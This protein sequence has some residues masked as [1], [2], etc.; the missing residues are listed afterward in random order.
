VAHLDRRGVLRIFGAVAVA[1]AIGS[2]SA[3]P[4][5]TETERPSGKAIRIGLV[6]PTQGPYAKIGD[7]IQK[8]FKLYLSSH[9]NL[10]GRHKVDLRTADEGTTPESASAAVKGLLEQKVIALA[11][12]ANPASLAAIAADVQEA[13]VPLVSSYAS[14]AT[15]TS[16][17]YVWRA[18]YVEGE[19][20][21]ALAPYAH[22][23][24]QSAYVLNE[25]TPAGREEASAFRSAFTDMGGR[26]V[27]QAE[28]RIPFATRLQVVK[29]S[30]AN[31]LFASYTGADAEA[32]LD[33]YRTS[34]LT[35]KLLGPASL[36]D[37]ADLSKLSALPSR[38]YTAMYYAADLNNEENRRFVSSY[39]NVHG[40]QPNAY[41]MAAYDSAA[42]LDKALHLVPDAPS[43]TEINK[44]FSM[45]GQIDSPR[46]VWTFNINRS[47]QQKWYLRRL[48]L[49]G[50]VPANLLDAELAV[51]S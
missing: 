12:V 48:Q 10:L 31:V 5:G 46:G 50:M 27:G 13:R 1:G 22:T 43:A 39:H 8:G 47:P 15:L 23:E 30:G 49:D 14:P 45:L 33:A 25:D 21:R 28:G 35:I 20:G 40:V 42:V 24:G 6:T 9:D 19:A 11:G 36:T 44:A 32:L 3:K 2:C 4:S 37:T 34:G 18:S 41:A 38:V 26:I 16:A 7:D 17:F 29:A 51:L